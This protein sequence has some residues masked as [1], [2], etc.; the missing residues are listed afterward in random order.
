[1]LELQNSR[2]RDLDDWRALFAAADPRFV[3]KSAKQPRGSRLWILE[4]VWD[5]EGDGD[6]VGDGEGEGFK[7][8]GREGNKGGEGDGER[9]SGGEVGRDV[10]GV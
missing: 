5:G 9:G 1:M 7:E 10:S 6:G 2:E 3:W 8:G 4:V